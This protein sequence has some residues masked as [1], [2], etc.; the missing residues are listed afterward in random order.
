MSNGLIS[1]F[2]VSARRQGLRPNPHLAELR[3]LFS[4]AC[5]FGLTAAERDE[6]QRRF[7]EATTA[8]EAQL[9]DSEA[10]SKARGNGWRLGE[11]LTAAFPERTA[12]PAATRRAV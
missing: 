9:A 4:A 6:W 1:I 11:R 2:E 10:H 12:K 3:A 5:R 8:L 7:D